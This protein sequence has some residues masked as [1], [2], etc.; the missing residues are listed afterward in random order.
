MSFSQHSSVSRRGGLRSVR[1]F[2]A[3][4]DEGRIQPLDDPHNPLQDHFLD[5]RGLVDARPPSRAAPQIERPALLQPG[6]HSGGHLCV[7]ARSR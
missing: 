6:Q 3:R 4:R 5:H 2:C 1:G 7:L